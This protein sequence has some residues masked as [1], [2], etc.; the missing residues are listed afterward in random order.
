MSEVNAK[1]R[2][3]RLSIWLIML[4][5]LLVIGSA[6]FV[7]Y[8][9]IGMPE[10]TTNE[11]TLIRPARDVRSLDFIDAAGRSFAYGEQEFK[12]T[13][14]IPGPGSCDEDCRQGLYTSRQ[15]H[16]AIGRL[17]PSLRRY[18][19]VMDP[20]LDAEAREFFAA[21]HADVTLLF[22]DSAGQQQLFGGIEKATPGVP[23]A[24]FLVDPGGFLML[25]YTEQHTYKQ[26]MKDLKFLIKESG[27]V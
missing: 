17:K 18:Y 22:L 3:D 24:W 13:L 14:L 15:M 16:T 21:E 11:G 20:E 9:G 26:V 1:Q 2:R 8:T 27:E 5:P 23:G 4:L 7:F 25:Y 19:L 10:G 6:S 12:W